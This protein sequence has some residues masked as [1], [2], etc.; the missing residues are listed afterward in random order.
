MG[1]NTMNITMIA[2]VSLATVATTLPLAAIAHADNGSQQFQTP[3]GNI[4]CTIHVGGPAVCDIGDYTYPP[5]KVTGGDSPCAVDDENRFN[6]AQGHP[7]AM[8]CQPAGP[9]LS[10]LHA[11][12]LATL[13]YGQTRS[14]GAITCDSE[15]SGMTCT[16]TSTGHFFRVARDSYQLA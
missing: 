2:A 6:L 4:A 1:N 12:G 14:A 16:D 10:D 7:A 15:P 8:W 3:S 11:P 13:D 9:A 5:P